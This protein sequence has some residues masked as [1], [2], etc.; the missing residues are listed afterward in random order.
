MEFSHNMPCSWFETKVVPYLKEKCPNVTLHFLFK[1]SVSLV[2]CDVVGTIGEI[3]E[4]MKHIV[5]RF[6]E[7]NISY[8]EFCKMRDPVEILMNSVQALCVC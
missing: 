8:D 7:V 2:T 4:R 5:H 1:D 3:E 6:K